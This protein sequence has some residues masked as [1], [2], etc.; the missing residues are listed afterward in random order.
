MLPGQLEAEWAAR[1]ARNG[2]LLFSE[3]EVNA[4]NEVAAEIRKPKWNLQ[5]LALANS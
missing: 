5:E 1:S 4:F 2:G 3:A